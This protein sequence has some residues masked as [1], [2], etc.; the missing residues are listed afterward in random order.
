MAQDWFRVKIPRVTHVC[1]GYKY[2]TKNLNSVHYFR[3]FAHKSPDEKII[4]S[5][6]NYQKVKFC[7]TIWLVCKNNECITSFTYYYNYSNHVITKKQTNG[8]KYILS[9]KDNF[10]DNLQLKIRVPKVEE[11]S[12]KYLWRYTDKHPTKANVSNI[13]TLDDKKVGETPPQNVKISIDK[14][15]L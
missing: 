3:C 14:I 11:V 6:G 4:D 15:L 2:D 8:L 5:T 13:Y 10:L 9:L 12:K 7:I 1:C